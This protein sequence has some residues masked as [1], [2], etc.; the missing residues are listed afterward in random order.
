MRVERTHQE[1]CDLIN[2]MAQS[3]VLAQDKM[4]GPAPTSSARRTRLMRARRRAQ[5]LVEHCLDKPVMEHG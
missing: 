4:L 5:A 1:L 2:G 3:I